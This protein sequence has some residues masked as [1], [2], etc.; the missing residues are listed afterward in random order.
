MGHDS[1]AINHAP[2]TW[3]QLLVATGGLA[4]QSGL[5][6]RE[7]RALGVSTD[8]RTL[9]PGNLFVALVG[10]NFNGYQFVSQAVERGA[11]AVVTSEPV[12]APAH[13]GVVRV[14]DTT[15]ALG[16]LAAFH[17]R[18]WASAPSTQGPGF[19]GVDVG[20]RVLV[21]VAGSVGKTST[22]RAIAALLRQMVGAAQVCETV[23]NHN[24]LVGV[25]MTL[26]SL[27]PE[28]RYAVVE[29]GTSVLGEMQLLC[30]MTAPD[31]GVLTR[32]TL[33]HPEGL[34]DLDSIAE[35]EGAL[36]RQLVHSSERREQGSPVVAIGNGDD[37][38]VSALLAGCASSVTTRRY[39]RGGD[40][41]VVAIEVHDEG[42]AG[43]AITIESHAEGAHL[44]GPLSGAIAPPPLPVRCPILGEAGVY[45]TLAAVATVRA[46][47]GRE[48]SAAQ[49]RA[50][51]VEV[52][53]APDA[54]LKVR[55]GTRGCVV[56]DDSYNA[57]PASMRASITS[58]RQLALRERRG[59]GVVL[60]EMRELGPYSGREHAAL[61]AWLAQQAPDWA[62]VIGNEACP[63]LDALRQAAVTVDW[64]ADSQAA[65]P[66][67]QS[68]LH[69]KDVVLVKAS[70]GIR[71]E[72]VVAAMV[73]SE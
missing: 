59:W 9:Q 57:S 65:V 64:A 47:T 14:P 2:F 51:L 16:A 36:L 34:G 49:V 12:S 31:V 20:G 28:H 63:L 3:E 17:R 19:V 8:T 71:A 67:V 18:R 61:G 69:D 30:A 50:A 7:V 5:P 10:P 23:G 68:R 4:A 38:R 35:E 25:P 53:S 37:E 40:N 39:G 1:I 33:E 42:R 11:V 70:R 27:T 60:G 72:R 13:V 73:P 66:L 26:L 6:A 44:T 52:A 29:L 48:V 62:V 56:I 32:I 24:N 41:D 54:R 22:R 15:A 21:A 45:V 55:E 46:V 43:S 58:A